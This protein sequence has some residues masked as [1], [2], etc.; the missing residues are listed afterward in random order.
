V[1]RHE[2]EASR[3]TLEAG[4]FQT[5]RDDRKYR[6]LGYGALFVTF[7]VFFGWASL[8]PLQSAVVAKG[9]IIVSSQ[10][11]IV[12]HLDGGLVKEIK[13]RDGDLVEQGQLLL[14]LDDTSLQIQLENTREQLLEVRAS[15]ERLVAER[16]EKPEL[17][18]SETLR[19]QASS[20]SAD[21]ILNTQRQLF[22]SRRQA[23][24]EER[25]VLQ[26]RLA[27]A[28]KQI[29]HSRKLILTLQQRL[30]L[31]N[32]DLKGLRQLAEKNLVSKSKLREVQRVGAELQGDIVEQQGVISGLEESKP[33]IMHQISLRKEEYKSEVNSGIHEFQ[34][35]L[36]DLS[37][38]ERDLLDKM[39]RIAI[40]APVAGKVK[41]FNVVTLGAVIKAGEPIME[42]VPLAQEFDIQA[43][44]SP[45]D[46]DVLHSGLKAEV[47]FPVFDGARRFPSLYASLQDISIDTYR[48]E[49]N[50]QSYYKATLKVDPDST[51]MLADRRLQL[52]SGMLVDVMINTGERTLMDYLI[53]PFEDMLARAFNE[54]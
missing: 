15:L 21:G 10:N 17:Q 20:A 8:A 3:R 49:S 9:R 51:E 54:A 2:M 47:R 42:I 33:E 37:A 7:V 29:A 41:G 30:S 40:R 13:V 53:A 44:V 28:E 35:R 11:K 25:D 48:D 46:I 1:A 24:V 4:N 19:R 22:Q 43:R 18:F 36:S 12:Q 45:M 23:Q 26:Q 32:E 34:S 39:S 6:I 16:D 5:S 38:R 31:V 14:S 50:D 27:Q 52:V